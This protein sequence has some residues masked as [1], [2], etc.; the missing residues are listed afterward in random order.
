MQ[1][2]PPTPVLPRRERHG[3]MLAAA[4]VV[5]RAQD[6]FDGCGR[7]LVAATQ[8]VLVGSGV[9]VARVRA[10]AM[11]AR[12]ANALLNLVGP[13]ALAAGVLVGEDVEL[14]VQPGLTG[15]QTLELE[16]QRRDLVLVG[17]DGADGLQQLA[18][19]LG[20]VG[21]GWHEVLDGVDFQILDH[22]GTDG[23]RGGGLWSV[24]LHGLVVVVGV[25]EID[26]LGR[27]HDGSDLSFQ[28]KQRTN[29]AVEEI[30]LHVSQ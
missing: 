3:A 5:R 8:V 23:G 9:D 4:A 6:R 12:L 16:T 21:Q 30:L 7:G 15:L 22:A 20:F 25:N 14:V 18:E 28:Q 27:G 1:L 19:F 24:D 17:V 10:V 13:V 29:P 11:Q 2:F 26:S